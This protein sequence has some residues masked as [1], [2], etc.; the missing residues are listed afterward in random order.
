MGSHAGRRRS[1]EMV[2]GLLVVDKPVGLTSHDMV[3]IVRRGVGQ[4]RV[5]HCGSLDPLASGVL[6]I[7]LGRATRLARF[8]TAMPKTYVGSMRLGVVTDTQDRCGHVLERRAVPPDVGSRLD[9]AVVG[10]RGEI[11]Q[12]P[13]MFSALKR[14]GVPLYRLART[15]RTVP[16]E[17][18]RVTVYELECGPVT[19]NRVDFR[20]V[21]SSGTYI[22]TICHDIGKTLGCGAV[23]STLRRVAVGR[24]TAENSIGMDVCGS[25][26]DVLDCILPAAEA[27][28]DL[29]PATIA[30]HDAASVAMGRSVAVMSVEG[31]CNGTTWV[32]IEEEDGRLLAVGELRDAGP[33]AG[34][35]SVWPRIVLE[36]PV[37]V[38]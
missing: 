11:L 29:P 8:V 6:V 36:E 16:R 7:C 13:P 37:C 33:E 23:M 31:E 20:I 18:R 22:R 21:C 19:R 5:G 9:D 35:P 38:S 3:N 24:F 14:N 26:Q 17:P 15:G 34:G 10:F 25:Q 30:P 12:V 2:H 28:S 4:R 27:V 32:R 1:G